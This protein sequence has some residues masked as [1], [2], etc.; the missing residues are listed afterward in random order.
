MNFEKAKGE[1]RRSMAAGNLRAAGDFQLSG[2]AAAYNTKSSNLGGFVEMIAPGA[3]ASALRGNA[4]VKCLFNHDA[5]AILGRVKNGTLKLTDSPEG[6]RYVCQLDKSNQ[7]H[8]S[9]YASIK[10]GDVDECSFAFTVPDGGDD[11]N[12]G[13]VLDSDGNSCVL[14]ILRNVSLIDV[15]AVVY[16][17]Y[18]NGTAVGARSKADYAPGDELRRNRVAEIGKLVEKDKRVAEIG[19]LVEKDKREMTAAEVSGIE[20]F[21]S[22][23]LDD[24]LKAYGYRLVSCDTSHCYAVPDSFDGDAEEEDCYRWPYQIDGG[25]HVILDNDSRETYG[26]GWVKS[27]PQAARTRYYCLLPERRALA[28]EKDLQRRMKTSA[29]IFH[30]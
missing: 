29:G 27:A 13:S 3:F 5:N 30:S 2:I 6:L 18:P 7:A 4:D 11:W 26:M 28:A 17:A 9:L 23:R 10:R 14:R 8:Q 24:A 15:S 12:S 1:Q 25:G 20:E 21:V 19:K 16:P 22:S